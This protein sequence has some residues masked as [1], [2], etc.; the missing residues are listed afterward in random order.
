M[1]G[2]KEEK[3]GDELTVVEDSCLVGLAL[4]WHSDVAREESGNGAVEWC[5][6]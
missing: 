5:R 2:K 3:K 4:G 1:E 6:C